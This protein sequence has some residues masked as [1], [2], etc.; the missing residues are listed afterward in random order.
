MTKIEIAMFIKGIE[1]P[2]YASVTTIDG[3]HLVRAS[4]MIEAILSVAE[5]ASDE[6]LGCLSR[7]TLY[8]DI[9]DRQ[10]IYTDYI[11]WNLESAFCG[12][13]IDHVY[14]PERMHQVIEEN[15]FKGVK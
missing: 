9:P 7:H 15:Y 5:E 10:A 6:V 13:L 12:E 3:N 1:T 8:A 14:F 2:R 11:I 4:E